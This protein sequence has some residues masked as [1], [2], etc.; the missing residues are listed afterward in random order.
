MAT[1]PTFTWEESWW[2]TYDWVIWGIIIAFAAIY[3]YILLRDH[4][5]QIGPWT[6]FIL[7]ITLIVGAFGNFWAAF[8]IILFYLGLVSAK[9]KA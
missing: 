3:F 4:R 9:T 2:D 5:S 1:R 8:G 6:W 7:V